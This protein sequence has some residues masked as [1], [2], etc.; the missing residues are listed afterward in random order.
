M[1]LEMR[2]TYRFCGVQ[3]RRCHTRDDDGASVAP[4]GILIIGF[5]WGD[6]KDGEGK[7][8]GEIEGEG[9][10]EW[11]FEGEMKCSEASGLHSTQE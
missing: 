6:E 3:M 9:E 4:K 2:C 10:R 8:V 5:V 1:I 11:E 7:R